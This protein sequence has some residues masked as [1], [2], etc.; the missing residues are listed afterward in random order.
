MSNQ[1]TETPSSKNKLVELT[2]KY[3]S[4]FLLI[5]IS[6]MLGFALTEWS[7]S[8][9]E[10]LSEEKILTEIKNGIVSDYKDLSNNIKGHKSSLRSIYVMRDWLNKKPVPQDSIEIYYYVL[11]RN[12]TPIINKSGYESLKA[13]NLKTIENDSLRSQII[14]LYDFHYKIIEKL[15]D[16]VL[17]MQDFNTYFKPINT[18]VYPYL[19]F[20]EKGKLVALNPSDGFSTNQRNELL[21]YL[22]RI[23]RNKRLKLNRYEGVLGEVYKLETAINNELKRIE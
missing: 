7:S 4:E 17:E 23:E 10:K 2:K 6:V 13:T 1:S 22:W 8:Q 14:T 19:V 20:D 5:F 18:I 11:F 16:N 12:F 3:F 15:E 9:G 21:S